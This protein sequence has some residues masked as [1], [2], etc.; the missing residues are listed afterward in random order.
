MMA[1]ERRLAVILNWVKVTPMA[2]KA[3]ILA[4]PM[5]KLKA[6]EG[7][8]QEEEKNMGAEGNQG[9]GNGLT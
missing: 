7:E 3:M 8:G 1:M 9:G 4:V 2:E 6:R 5:A